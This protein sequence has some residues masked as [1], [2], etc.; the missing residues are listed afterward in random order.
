MSLVTNL[1]LKSSNVYNLLPYTLAKVDKLP[2]EYVE[3]VG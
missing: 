1:T 2:V 3:N